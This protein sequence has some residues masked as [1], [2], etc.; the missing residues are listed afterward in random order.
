M[1]SFLIGASKGY[2]VDE[3]A[4]ENLKFH[5]DTVASDA[6]SPLHLIRE[7]EIEISGQMLAAKRRADEIVADARKKAA[8]IINSAQEEGSE[9]AR[10]KEQAI[11]AEV[12][13]DISNVGTQAEGEAAALEGTIA[14]RRDE[15]TA[16]VI[17]TV[18]GG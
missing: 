12:E 5:Q 2:H 3:K 11:R 18:M 7:K 15:A 16:F 10:Q 13:R 4:V 9:L 8:G 1:R 17:K 6:N 14:Q